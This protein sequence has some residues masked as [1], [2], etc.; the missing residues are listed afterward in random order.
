M[1]SKHTF[2]GPLI[3]YNA[4]KITQ[5]LEIFT[6]EANVLWGVRERVMADGKKGF[7]GLKVLK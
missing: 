5:K 6:N 4:P 7:Q 3:H 2:Q 1:D